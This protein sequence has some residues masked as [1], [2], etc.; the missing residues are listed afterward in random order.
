MRA[1]RILVMFDLP[2][3]NTS[4]RHSYTLFR[5]FL[6][7]D[8]YTMEQYSVYSRVTL[9]RDNME[10]HIERL[11]ANLPEAGSVIV[12][13]MTEKQYEGRMI[14]LGA[15]QKHDHANNYGSQMTLVF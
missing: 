8:G 1:M 11:R 5:K 13:T 7:D 2:T 14:M 10:T 9:G 15:P 3:G 12:M 4:Q 6:L